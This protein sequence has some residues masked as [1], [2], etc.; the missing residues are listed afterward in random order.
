MLQNFALDLRVGRGLLPI[1]GRWGSGFPSHSASQC[2]IPSRQTC[3]SSICTSWSIPIC[4]TG[5][6]CAR[7]WKRQATPTAR[8]TGGPCRSRTSTSILWT[9]KALQAEALRGRTGER[10]IRPNHAD[11]GSSHLRPEARQRQALKLDSTYHDGELGL[12]ALNRF[13]H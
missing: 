3:L 9:R 13:L 7:P 11:P 8:F 1:W 4:I 2:P 6:A 12:R 10:A 5:R